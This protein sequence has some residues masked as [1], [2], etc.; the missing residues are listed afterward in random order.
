MK[1]LVIYC[2]ESIKKGQ[3]CS[4]FYGGALINEKNT[5]FII[6]QLNSVKKSIQLQ[7]EIKWTNVSAQLLDRYIIFIDKYF[8]FIE[9][10]QIKIRIMFKQEYYKTIGLTENQKE[11]EFYILYYQFCRHAFGLQ[12]CNPSRE[13]IELKIFFDRLPNKNEQNKQFKLYIQNLQNQ[14]IFKDNNIKIP[15]DNITDVDSK[16]HII[17]QGMDVILGSMKFKLN[18]ENEIVPEGSRR[19]GKKTVAK[20]KLYKHIHKRLN[21]M[22]PNFN[23]GVSTGMQPNKSRIWEDRYRHWN[24]IS[25]NHEVDKSRAKK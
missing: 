20:E 3:Y 24:F 23:I 21:K 12:Y 19:R 14:D 10:N 1:K 9:S 13:K 18:K 6:D 8:D 22:Y 11:E 25:S 4:N 15:L 5:N 2:D 16:K 17:L 7:G